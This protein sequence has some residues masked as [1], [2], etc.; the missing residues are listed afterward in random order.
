MIYCYARVSSDIQGKEG[1]SLDIQEETMKKWAIQLGEDY[2]VYREI[3]SGRSVE[4]RPIFQGLLSSMEKGDTLMVIDQT[5]LGRNSKDD[6]EVAETIVKKGIRLFM[7]GR[8]IDL[9]NPN[10]YFLFTM[11]SG[12]ATLQ[13]RMQAKKSSDAVKKTRESGDWVF[14]STLLGYTLIIRGGKT[15]VEEEPQSAHYI[16]YIYDEVAKGRTPNSLSKELAGTVVPT[17]P[18]CQFCDSTVRDILRKPLY[19]GYYFSVP[20]TRMEMRH[21]DRTELEKRLVKSNKY[22]ALV[23]EETFWKVHERIHTDTKDYIQFRE[24]SKSE[25]S[26]LIKCGGCGLHSAKDAH[27]NGAVLLRV[28]RHLNYCPINVRKGY[29]EDQYLWI[30]RVLYFLTFQFGDEVGGFVEEKKHLA[31]LDIDD[32]EKQ[33][34]SLEEDRRG[35]DKKIANLMQSVEEGNSYSN[36][37]DRVGELE[38]RKKR[39]D[40]QIDTLKTSI[41]QKNLYIEETIEMSAENKIAELIE[42]R[43]RRKTMMELLSAKQFLDHMEVDFINGKKWVIEDNKKW[44]KQYTP[45]RFKMYYKG[46]LQ[47]EGY[48]DFGKQDIR[49][50]RVEETDEFRKYVNDTYTKMEENVKNLIQELIQ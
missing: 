16:R 43:N 35:C 41:L 19:M 3:K 12:F 23:S 18:K 28:S 47:G 22:P 7:D 44:S 34:E 45:Q 13:T 10:D 30:M 31:N 39:I 48:L 1:V 29:H 4:K 24:S 2:E 27:K 46:E 32:L 5:R 21:L 11:N 37:R 40:L 49:F 25:L 9:N 36:V 20:T 6:L 38:N 14:S 50:D 33:I 8:Y 17:F 42:G 15:L 26:G